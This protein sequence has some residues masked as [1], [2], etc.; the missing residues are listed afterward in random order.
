MT[1]LLAQSEYRAPPP[2]RPWSVAMRWDDLLF[3][4]WPVR[5]ELLRSLIP[6]ELEIDTF[7]G[8]AWLG[9]IPFQ[10]S[11]VRL[12]R[13]PHF[14]SMSFAELNV[15]TYVRTRQ[16]RG[17]WFFSLDAQHRLAVRVAR[18]WYGVPYMDARIRVR[19]EGGCI[20]YESKRTQRGAPPAEFQCEYCP[21][22][23]VFH[24]EPDTLEHWLI[25][26][27]TLF[28]VNRRGQVCFGDVDHAPWSLQHVD[29]EI[30][31]NTMCQAA[32][33]TLP[34]QEPL[35]HFAREVDAVAWSVEPLRKR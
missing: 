29:A 25:E 26:R 30:G 14:C 7:D 4:H 35:L 28:S 21:V 18:A 9:V 12:R 31:V 3:A 32:G 15:R 20:L 8:W 22:G 11:G 13:A 2:K 27:Y 5:A 10:L 33:L 1:S 34:D 17:I 24:A 16:R 23:R 6:A 19:S